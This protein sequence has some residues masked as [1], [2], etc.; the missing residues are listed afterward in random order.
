MI[1]ADTTSF[2]NSPDDQPASSPVNSNS[3]VSAGLDVVTPNSGEDKVQ[4]LH[5]IKK[6]LNLTAILGAIALF[7]LIVGGVAGFYLTGKSQETRQQASGG[8]QGTSCNSVCKTNTD[9]PANYTC[10]A[11]KCVATACLNSAGNGATNN[12]PL[13]DANKCLIVQTA[14]ATCNKTCSQ[15]SDCAA[16]STCLQAQGNVMAPT[17]IPPVYRLFSAKTFDHLFTT[18]AAE[19]DSFIKN[20][21]YVAEA[22][23]FY[24][25]TTQKTGSSPVYRL[26]NKKGDHLYTT[27]PAEQKNAVSSGY[28]AEGIAFYA[29]IN[30]APVSTP[31]NP[32]PTPTP[33]CQP[34]PACLDAKPACSVPAVIGLPYCPKSTMAPTPVMPDPV[35]VPNP[36]TPSPT[37][38]PSQSVLGVS[39]TAQPVQVIAPYPNP[40]PK[41]PTPTSAP[42]C[43]P[44][45]ACLDAKPA[46]LIAQQIGV[47]YCP[48]ASTTP[49][50][51]LTNNSE[52]GT[53]P[54]YGLYNPKYDTH[55][56]TTSVSERDTAINTA[57]YNSV[58]IAF[59]AFPTG[60]VYPPSIGVCRNTS[61]VN[62]A[63]CTCDGNSGNTQLPPAAPPF[64]PPIIAKPTPAPS[65]QPRPACLDAKPACSVPA[66]IGLPYCPSSGT[67][68]TQPPATTTQVIQAKTAVPDTIYS[69]K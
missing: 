68:Q 30:P 44:R 5:P 4:A 28:A 33:S 38:V 41:I 40:S 17:V 34:R 31:T 35:A 65:C 66:V 50:P 67:T 12:N 8:N 46:C 27:D 37:V 6:K 62:S 58:G 42:T 15:A 14:A 9:C 2:T 16:G 3:S 10:S 13:C 11:N 23:G 64:M 52:V 45:P 20:S 29:Y 47:V 63:T 22:T 21:G 54:V 36:K 43:V 24:A 51:V 57:G 61:C 55:F 60:L 56:Y 32:A 69:N 18:N 25:Y 49:A 19:R 48:T 26:V 53:V 59:Y 1:N 7:V 39:T